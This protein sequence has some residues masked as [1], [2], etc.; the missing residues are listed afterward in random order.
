MKRIFI[1][2]IINWIFSFIPSIYAQELFAKESNKK[3]GFVDKKGLWIIQPKY[4]NAR[5][6][7]EGVGAIQ[8][9]SKWGFIS[10]SG[11]LSI[12]PKFGYVQDFSEGKAAVLSYKQLAGTNRNDHLQRKWGYIDK[13]GEFAIPYTFRNANNF[14]GGFALVSNWNQQEKE[15][16]MIDTSGKATSVPFI[17]KRRY[18]D[19]VFQIVNI[20][21]DGDSVYKYILSDGRDVTDWYSKNF[22]F[23]NFPVK[24]YLPSS[25]EDKPTNAFAGD[26][27]I[28]FVAL[29]NEKG[30]VFTNWFNE[31]LPFY[32][33]FAPIR[34]N[35]K[36]GFVDE[37]Y[38]WVT[39]PI[40]SDIQLLKN[41]LYE[42]QFSANSSALI[43]YKGDIL[44][45]S[46]ETI[47]VFD[48]TFFIGS[49]SLNNRRNRESFVALY[50]SLG[51][52]RTNWYQKINPFQIG[53]AR[54]EEKKNT[55]FLNDSVGL[56]NW[57]NYVVDSTGEVLSFWRPE[58]LIS[59]KADNKKTNDSILNYL[60]APNA[61]KHLTEEYF[62][63]IYLKTISI[64]KQSK[65]IVFAGGDFSEGMALVAKK[66]G[67]FSKIINGVTFTADDI[68]YGYIDWKGK[69]VIPYQ[70]KEASNFSGGKAIISDGKKYGAIDFNGK[71]IIK[72]QYQL[73]GS[74]GS[75]LAPV[76]KDSV[77][78]FV[79]AKNKLVIPYQYIDVRTFRFGYAAVKKENEWGLIDTKGNLVLD[80]T[81]KK[82]PIPKSAKNIEVLKKGVGYVIV[83]L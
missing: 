4:Q 9:G 23:N 14:D 6:F 29:L 78:G 68:R 49:Y 18:N 25:L 47:E 7:K 54:V 13:S 11:K 36:W 50:D 3:W 32:K 70:Y 76:F 52:Q 24:V 38:N 22:E 51:K 80:F 62:S 41:G 17:T 75:G 1:I 74:F 33:N 5:D 55:R 8:K 46:F 59:W 57:Y 2:L 27:R 73:M 37:D 48:S 72:P 56:K 30:I 63:T 53:I 31:I 65:S 19:S 34:Y 82:P 79:S 20:R 40:F 43:N 44:S 71:L 21:S 16:Y 26:N 81:Y 58:M 45:H 60:Y 15:I 83:E 35:H 61:N 10:A 77:W 42:G 67:V 66:I 69:Q 64:N 12:K 39:E 28:V